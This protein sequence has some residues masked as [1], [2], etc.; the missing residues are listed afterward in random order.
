MMNRLLGAA[1]AWE[2][3]R[4]TIEYFLLGRPLGVHQVPSKSIGKTH[5]MGAAGWNE[6]H[7]PLMLLKVVWLNAS[8]LLEPSEVLRIKHA[9]LQ[10]SSTFTCQQGWKIWPRA[11]QLWLCLSVEVSAVRRWS[12]WD[13]VHPKLQ[14]ADTA[15]VICPL[16][17]GLAL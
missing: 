4:C 1:A 2:E 6:D 3:P 16:S 11:C 9:A 8:V 5:L 12:A 7:L 13:P 15:P 10:A 14:L 17:S